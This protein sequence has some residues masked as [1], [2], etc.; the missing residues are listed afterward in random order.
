MNNYFKYKYNILLINR[1]KLE[2]RVVLLAIVVGAV[3]VLTE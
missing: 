3:S 1:M 2:V